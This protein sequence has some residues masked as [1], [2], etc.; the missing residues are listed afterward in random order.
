MVL[1]QSRQ[2]RE[3]FPRVATAVDCNLLRIFLTL[4]TLTSKELSG[5]PD[6]SGNCE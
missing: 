3:G 5:I 6:E 1:A 4:A 2:S